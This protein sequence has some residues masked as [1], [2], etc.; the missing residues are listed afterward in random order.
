MSGASSEACLGY[1]LGHVWGMSGVSL[2]YVWGIILGMYGACMGLGHHLGHVWGIIWGFSGAGLAVT[3]A[4]ASYSRLPSFHF[5]LKSE[6]D[7]RI[8]S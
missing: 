1:H 4:F 5:R 7:P 2:G 6:T 3:S 8:L